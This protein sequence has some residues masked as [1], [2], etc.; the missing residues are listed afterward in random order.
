MWGTLICPAK[1]SLKSL[2]LALEVRLQAATVKQ[3]VLI[4]LSQHTSHISKIK[5]KWKGQEHVM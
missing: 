1:S 4:V 5:I 3:M 2:D